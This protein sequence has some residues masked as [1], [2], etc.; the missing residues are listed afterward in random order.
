MQA[1]VRRKRD[2]LPITEPEP[3]RQPGRRNTLRP[4]RAGYGGGGGQ[5]CGWG[6][7][8]SVGGRFSF[9]SCLATEHHHFGGGGG[10]A[11]WVIMQASGSF[12]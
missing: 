12:G 3:G 11:E 2:P 4:G 5:V 1:G 9:T 8:G 6:A 10:L 7:G